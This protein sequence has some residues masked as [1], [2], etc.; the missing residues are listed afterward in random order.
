MS[1]ILG[2]Y[3]KPT[4]QIVPTFALLKFARQIIVSNQEDLSTGE[5]T[6]MSNLMKIT[7]NKIIM[8]TMGF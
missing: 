8:F 5:E 3:F 1:E 7:N 6:K 4:D 2:M